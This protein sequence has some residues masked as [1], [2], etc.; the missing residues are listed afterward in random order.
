MNGSWVMLVSHVIS[1]CI[2]AKHWSHNCKSWHSNSSFPDG[3]V[4]TRFLDT[5]DQQTVNKKELYEIGRFPN[6]I[7][8]TDCTHVRLKPTSANDYAFISHRNHHPINVFVHLWCLKHGSDLKETHDSIRT[9]HHGVTGGRSTGTESSPRW[10]TVLFEWLTFGR[11]RWLGDKGSP[12]T[13]HLLTP[14]AN[15]A[16]KQEPGVTVHT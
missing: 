1:S 12:P 3:V 4:L 2:D 8:A 9:H 15:P 16:T 5:D 11:N 7:G 10:V 13:E 6:V 14:L